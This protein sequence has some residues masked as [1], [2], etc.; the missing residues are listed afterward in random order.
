M[1][2][3]LRRRRGPQLRARTGIDS[4][5]HWQAVAAVVVDSGRS[6]VGMAG[7]DLHFAPRDSRLESTHDE[8]RTQ[9]VGVH[10]AETGSFGDRADPRV[11]RAPV[12]PVPSWRSRIGPAVRSPIARSIVRAVLCTRGMTAGLF[13]L[14]TMRSVRLGWP[15]GRRTYCAEV[16][17]DPAVDVGEAAEAADGGQPP[18][19]GGRG[20][21]AMFD[22][23]DV[24][25]RSGVGSST[26]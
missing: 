18:V 13:A 4:T 6:R 20:N 12:K 23:S 26:G 22:G 15:F 1:A 24:E 7:G 19:D 17:G 3:D 14:P 25:L 5:P 9:H 11:G 10:V 21:A 16:G 8:R 2:E